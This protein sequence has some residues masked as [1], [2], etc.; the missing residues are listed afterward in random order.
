MA[1]SVEDKQRAIDV[2]QWRLNLRIT[3]CIFD[4]KRLGWV[5]YFSQINETTPL[6][7]IDNTVQRLIQ[8]FSLEGVIKPKRLLKTFYEGRRVDV[9]DHKYIPNFDTMDAKEQRQ[10][11]AT[12][13]GENRIKGVPDRRISELFKMRISAAVRELE[14]DIT[15]TS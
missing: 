3:G 12:L 8:R 1:R 11:L 9:E 7:G 4:G 15:A 13:L 2:C 6:R 5:F 14:E 10:I